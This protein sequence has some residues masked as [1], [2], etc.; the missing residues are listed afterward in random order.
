M[1][2]GHRRTFWKADVRANWEPCVLAGQLGSSLW[3]RERWNRDGGSNAEKL[4]G[5]IIP[6]HSCAFLSVSPPPLSNLTLQ[7]HKF[8]ILLP[9]QQQH[10]AVQRRVKGQPH[11]KKSP[12]SAGSH[13][14]HAMG[15]ERK[16]IGSIFLGTGLAGV[17]AYKEQPW[18]EDSAGMSK[19][20]EG[21]LGL[22]LKF[23]LAVQRCQDFV[24]GPLYC[25]Q[26]CKAPP[27]MI[28]ADWLGLN[29]RDPCQSMKGVPAPDKS[30]FSFD[31]NTAL[32][33]FRQ[34]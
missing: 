1:K 8:Q 21:D 7:I 20:C 11:P 26:L 30:S 18:S 13:E 32:K 25:N 10:I 19:G 15:F 31:L 27:I 2:V 4:P 24:C 16:C 6:P 22:S 17:T 34:L 3:S 23:F 29:T 5:N 14:S 9:W 28:S 12:R 33:F